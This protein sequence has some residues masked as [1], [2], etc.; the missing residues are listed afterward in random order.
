MSRLE[1]CLQC[2]LFFSVLHSY[3]A[4][5]FVHTYCHLNVIAVTVEQLFHTAT[6]W[7]C[8]FKPPMKQII[9]L[10]IPQHWRI[11]GCGNALKTALLVAVAVRRD[12]M[13]ESMG[14]KET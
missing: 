2:L 8:L 13:V 14:K 10:V 1:V 9:K 5:H 11:A 12:M 7:K 6:I 4:L 3:M